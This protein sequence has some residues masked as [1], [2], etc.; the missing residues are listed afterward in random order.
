MNNLETQY[1]K[2]NSRVLLLCTDE[3]VRKATYEPDTCSL[4]PWIFDDDQLDNPFEVM[5]IKGWAYDY[6]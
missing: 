5:H 2:P 6:S 1:P 4:T 3:K